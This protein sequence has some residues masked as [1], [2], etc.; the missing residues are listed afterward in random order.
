LAGSIEPATDRNQDAAA[1]H[2]G[3]LSAEKKVFGG[4]KRRCDGFLIILLLSGIIICYLFFF[5][6]LSS[7]RHIVSKPDLF[8]LKG[9]FHGFIKEFIVT[10]RHGIK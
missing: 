6:K 9:V 8:D 2:P 1:I 4:L 5:L 10:D 3:V 7:H